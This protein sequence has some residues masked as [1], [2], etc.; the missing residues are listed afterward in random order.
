MRN[1]KQCCILYG[2]C[3]WLLSTEAYTHVTSMHCT[4]SWVC[5]LTLWIGCVTCLLLQVGRQVLDWQRHRGQDRH[6][7]PGL[8]AGE[9]SIPRAVPS[10][11]PPLLLKCVPAA[12]PA[13]ARLLLECVDYRHHWCHTRCGALQ[14]HH[15]LLRRGATKAAE[16]RSLHLATCMLTPVFLGLVLLQVQYHVVDAFLVP[17]FRW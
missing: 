1:C 6:R 14:T 16:Q 5:D 10:C 17:K 9:C 4:C 15:L 3:M 12:D 2:W 13:C 11:A 8:W 7:G